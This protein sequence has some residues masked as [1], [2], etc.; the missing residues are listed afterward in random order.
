MHILQFL[1]ILVFTLYIVF[2]ITLV[3]YF[4]MFKSNQNTKR[5]EGRQG[6]SISTESMTCQSFPYIH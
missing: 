3:S 5:E 1:H 2:R 6:E 4:F